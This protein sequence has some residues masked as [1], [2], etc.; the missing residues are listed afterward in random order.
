MNIKK[1]KLVLSLFCLLSLFLFIQPVFAESI[2]FAHSKVFRSGTPEIP[3]TYELDNG[4]LLFISIKDGEI[5][6]K[7]AHN[8]SLNLEDS[9]ISNLEALLKSNFEKGNYSQGICSYIELLKEKR[10]KPEKYE[11]NAAEFGSKTKSMTPEDR[12]LQ[13]QGWDIKEGE[14]IG[15]LLWAAI[16][17]AI[18]L[19]GVFYPFL[20][21]IV[22]T[23]IKFVFLRNKIED[24]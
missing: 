2:S 19:I 4:I 7:I 17:C 18:P 10:G 14:R 24:K 11:H 3:D 15:M 9:F 13:R 5:R 23:I 20:R 16:L 6:T 22:R 12:K 8:N 1:N 21:V